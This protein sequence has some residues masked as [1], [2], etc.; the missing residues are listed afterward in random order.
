M[1]L[2]HLSYTVSR[3][4]IHTLYAR[5]L[6]FQPELIDNVLQI[7]YEEL[8]A[9]TSQSNPLQQRFLFA[10]FGRK[11]VANNQQR[12][13][14]SKLKFEQFAQK[15]AIFQ[16]VNSGSKYA[17]ITSKAEFLFDLFDIQCENVLKSNQVHA[18]FKLINKS[19][20][21][22]DLS[23][24]EQEDLARNFINEIHSLV[25]IESDLEVVRKE[26]FVKACEMK[27]DIVSNLRILF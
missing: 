18:V 11:K 23:T 22:N 4:Q 14:K 2:K 1:F 8:E 3:K 16:N 9:Q 15:M 12:E 5:F 25:N 20:Y 26:D 24:Q 10:L 19:R 6:T 27:P 17:T 21:R 7:S 13:E